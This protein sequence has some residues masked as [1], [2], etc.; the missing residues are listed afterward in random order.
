[1]DQIGIVVPDLKAAM[2]AYIANLGIAF[3]VFDVD[4]KTSVFSGSS[5]SFQIR[6]A[7]ALVGSSSIELI[8]PVSGVTIYSDVL[9][10]RGPGI[11]HMGI[12]V[13]DLPQAK[14]AMEHRGYKARMEG[15]IHSLGQFSYYDAPDMHCIVE[16][17][18]LS[19]ALPLFLAE[20]ATLYTG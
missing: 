8:Q 5:A 16:L 15:E 10:T 13:D 7:V 2:D 17:L 3:Q 11:H 18:H 19:L 4:E 1:M 6:F 20:N 9:K 14:K 12:Y